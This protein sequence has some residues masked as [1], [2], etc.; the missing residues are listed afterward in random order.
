MLIAQLASVTVLAVGA[1]TALGTTAAHA[2][3]IT[4][5]PVTLSTIGTVTAGTPYSSGQKIDIAV[6]AN[7][8]LN[9]A[10]LEAA[11]FPSGAVPIKA[12]ECSDPG[13]TA[14]NLPTNATECQSDT[15]AVISGANSDGSL[16]INNYTVYALPDNIIFSEGASGPLC[17]QADAC[18]VGI[19][20]NQ[21]DFTKPHLFSGPFYVA[22]N[23]DDGGENPGDGSPPPVTT[24]SATQS[25]VVATPT[26]AAANATASS[27]VT[28]TLL[29]SSSSPVA[30]KVVTL[31][32][33]SGHSIITTVSGTTNSSGQATFTVTD[34]TVESVTYTATD[35]TD[36]NLVITETAKVTFLP[37]SATAVSCKP[38]KAKEGKTAT[39]T[40]KVKG[41]AKKSPKATGTVAWSGG[42]GSFGTPSCTLNSKGECSVTFVPSA[43]GTQTITGA[44]S[45]NANLAPSAGT[46]SLK[47]T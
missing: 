40:A 28:V 23:G 11:G 21:N 41:V 20:S 6:A 45:G 9:Q 47:V 10:S 29:T 1:S 37:A 17:D 38:K 32:Q 14:A 46:A 16:N 30:G 3:P 44:Y 31:A 36:S 25:T 13:G 18:V 19:F 7:S 42:T 34:A 22:P 39:C 15:V 5:G 8:T 2:A 27:T 24:V 26:A 43:E 35:T 33:G 12:L 4:S